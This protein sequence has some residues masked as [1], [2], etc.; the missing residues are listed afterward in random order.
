[1]SPSGAGV[2]SFTNSQRKNPARINGR[3]FS[4]M[5][6]STLVGR[7]TADRRTELSD[8]PAR[9]RNLWERAVQGLWK[10]NKGLAARDRLAAPYQG[11]DCWEESRSLRSRGFFGNGSWRPGSLIRQP[12]SPKPG[13]LFYLPLSIQ[14]GQASVPI[15]RRSLALARSGAIHPRPGHSKNAR[16]AQRA[17]SK[18][19]SA[20]LGGWSRERAGPTPS[21]TFFGK[22]STRTS[23]AQTCT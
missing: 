21:T 12:P 9:S 23:S 1:M 5:T 10:D 16:D 14:S 20:C 18:S 13:L 7:G 3:V 17:G 8:E 19:D 15:H 4:Y 2:W 22:R 6:M 11:M